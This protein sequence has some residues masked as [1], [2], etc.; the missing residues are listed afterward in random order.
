MMTHFIQPIVEGETEARCIERLLHRIWSESLQCPFRLQVLRAIPEPR[1]RLLNETLKQHVEIACAR[2]KEK[3][4][5][6]PQSKGLVLI[7]FDADDDCPVDIVKIHKSTISSTLFGSISDSLII[8][9]KMFENWLIAGCSGYLGRFGMPSVDPGIQDAETRKGYSWMRELLSDRAAN[10]PYR[11]IVDGIDL[12]K[13]F[14]I[15]EASLKSRSFRK[16]LSDLARWIHTPS[17][18]EAS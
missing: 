4:D 1:N 2:L 14:D 16:L 8:A 15:A 7:L 18:E 13:S 10:K 6:L 17:A 9:N 11:K 3:V 12:T 5:H